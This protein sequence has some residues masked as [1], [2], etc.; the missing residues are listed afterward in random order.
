MAP[1][2]GIYA[3]QISGHLWAPSGAYDSIA[4]TTVGAGGVSSVTFSSIPQGYT[5]LQVRGIVRTTATGASDSNY[6]LTSLNGDTTTTNYRTHALYGDGGTAAS[7]SNHSYGGALYSGV[8][9]KDTNTAGIMGAFVIDILDYKNTSK[10]K[11]IR[12]LTGADLN[13]SAGIIFL[14]SALWINTSAV[15]SLTFSIAFAG[16]LAQ[17]SQLAL[18]GIKGE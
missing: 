9:P 8:A 6:M 12:T 2:L 7:I 4:T 15:N 1:I 17:Y 16:N 11:T 14:S 10:N 13:N 18:Y 3:S 5:H